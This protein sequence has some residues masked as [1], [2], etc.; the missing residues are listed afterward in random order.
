MRVTTQLVIVVMLATAGAGAWC[1]NDQ[2]V[3]QAAEG[4]RQTRGGGRP[5]G[6]EVAKPRI[7]TVAVTVEAVGTALANEAVNITP[8][9]SGIIGKISFK[10][11]GRVKKG[12]VLVELDATELNANLEEQ[13]IALQQAQRLY[14][15]ALALFNNRT[16][17]RARID[18]LQASLQGA[19]ARV[20]ANEARLQD[21]VI[22][23]PFSG[24]LGLRRVSVGA[25][26]NPGMEITT[27]DD[28]SS[29]KVDFRVPESVLALAKPGLRI[30]AE[31]V[32]YSEIFDGIVKTLDSRI[33]PVTQSIE[34]RTEFPNPDGR[35]KPG[36]FL[37]AKLSIDSRDNAVLVP[38]EALISQGATHFVFLVRDGK[39][40]RTRVRIGERLI[41]EVEILEGVSADDSVVVR[42]LQ[43]IR[44]GS[45]VKPIKPGQPSPPKGTS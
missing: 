2:R 29:V 16:V 15:R 44:D 41:G 31:S 22:R 27:L 17:S 28:I 11:G 33:D 25:L 40:S 42:G 36:M 20:R 8:K 34:L 24:R 45:T 9:V 13:R 5:V 19:K 30:Q 10:E 18:E 7:A 6:V 14:D 32:T 37:T 35:L 43:K 26:V 39:A 23:A 38:E 3:S 12:D 1:W 4:N 21:Y